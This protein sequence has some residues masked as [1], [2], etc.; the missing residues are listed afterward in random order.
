MFHFS[1]LP[2]L[3]RRSICVYRLLMLSLR[4]LFNLSSLIVQ[5]CLQIYNLL[6]ILLLYPKFMTFSCKIFNLVLWASKWQYL[7]IL[8][9]GATPMQELS[10]AIYFRTF[11]GYGYV[12]FSLISALF[13]WSQTRRRMTNHNLLTRA[14]WAPGACR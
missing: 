12:F 8:P 7:L 11:F 2:A 3:H 6:N 14:G 5:I 1:S 13:K 10:F 9:L 4:Q